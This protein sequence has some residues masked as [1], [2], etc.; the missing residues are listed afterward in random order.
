MSSASREVSI[1]GEKFGKKYNSC[2][3]R[4]FLIFER[5]SLPSDG[6]NAQ[7]SEAPTAGGPFFTITGK[8]SLPWIFSR[9]PRSPS[10]PCFFI[11]SHDRRQ[12]LHFNI[13]RHPTSSWVVQQL[14]K[15]FPY[16]S[17]RNSYSSITTRNMALKSLLPF[18]LSK[19]PAC[20]ESLAKHSK[21]MFLFDCFQKLR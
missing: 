15:A 5:H 10:S 4:S 18:A 21:N 16:E 3:L 9:S 12:I 19:S 20:T 11:I 17:A 8:R 6:A 13:A 1:E 14:R 7:R 2:R